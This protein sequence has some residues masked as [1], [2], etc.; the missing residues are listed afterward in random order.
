MVAEQRVGTSTRGTSSPGGFRRGLTWFVLVV[1]VPVLFAC[2][3]LGG[4][5]QV[6]GVPVVH[7]SMRFLGLVKPDLPKSRTSPTANLL[8]TE[9]IRYEQLQVS[10]QQVN[11]RFAQSQ[12]EVVRLKA[13]IARLQ[14]QLSHQANQ[15]T[16]A[17]TEAQVLTSM[18]PGQAALVVSKMQLGQA[19]L[20]MGAMSPTDSGPILAAMDPTEAAKIIVQASRGQ[21]H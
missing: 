13:D 1:L 20:V 19:V 5:L 6:L 3:L 9:R 15:A 17:K 14:S 2:L 18:E 8:K 11:H 10:D 16:A 4:A 21:H 12:T 7:D